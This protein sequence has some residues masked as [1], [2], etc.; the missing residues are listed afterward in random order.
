MMDEPKQKKYYT[1]SDG[2]KIEMEKVETTHLSNGYAKKYR[3]IFNSKTRDEFF[4][5]TQE[6]KD[7]QEELYKRLNV[8][9]ETNLGEE[10]GR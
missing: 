1:S 5:R 7:I 10:D 9:N 2:T 6:L 8:F 4:Q 3:E